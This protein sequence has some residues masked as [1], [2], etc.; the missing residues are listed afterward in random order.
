MV[1]SFI[2]IVALGCSSGESTSA[3]T[4]AATDTATTVDAAGQEKMICDA[5]ASRSA[6]PGGALECSAEAKC[7]Y[8]RV[9]LPAAASAWVACR[10]APSCKK[11]D[12]CVAAAG[13]AVGGAAADKYGTDC[14]AR[15]PLFDGCVRI[16]ERRDGRRGMHHKTM[17]SDR[18]V[19]WDLAGAEGHRGV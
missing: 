19:F 7:I 8:G 9:M 17:R 2:V 13:T 11:D 18:R 1:R 12:E 4:D 5:L 15:R 3:T 10:S 14:L 16:C 6:C